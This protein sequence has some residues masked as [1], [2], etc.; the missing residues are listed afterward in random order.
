[1]ARTKVRVALSLLKDARLVRET[2]GVRFK[3]LRP[4]VTREEVERAADV[5]AT[6]GEGDRE[7]LER[8]MLYGQSAEC[9]W[10]LLHEYF[11][12]ELAPGACGHCD[13]CLH[14]L[15][16]RLGLS[17]PEAEAP[18]PREGPPDVSGA[19]RMKKVLEV[20]EG[21]AVRV[22]KYGRGRVASLEDDKVAVELPDGETRT[23]KR[24]FV[25]RG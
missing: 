24:E 5:C 6:R 8:V 20:S 25:R 4:G 23:F 22:P 12:E 7:K 19:K 14:P 11:G 9:R 18:A 2:R 21:D 3:L 1:M 17:T 13:N 10:K 16:E 15:E